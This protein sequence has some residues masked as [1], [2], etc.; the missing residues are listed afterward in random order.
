MN[1]A[2]FEV[3]LPRGAVVFLPGKGNTWL[4]YLELIKYLNEI[5]FT[6]YATDLPGQGLSSRLSSDPYRCI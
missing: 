1:V 3:N 6:V 4:E 2:T 5:G